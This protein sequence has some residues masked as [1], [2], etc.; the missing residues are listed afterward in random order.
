MHNPFVKELYE[1]GIFTNS[2]TIPKINK[3]ILQELADNIGITPHLPHDT[4]HGFIP[5]CKNC[6]I[7]SHTL[8]L[9]V[10]HTTSSDITED[11]YSHK[12]LS[13]LINAVNKLPFEN[14]KKVEQQ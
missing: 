6:D 3:Q 9:I 8:K 4:R 5:L 14:H 11:I 7:D 2:L 12:P 13:Q 1:Q 10:G